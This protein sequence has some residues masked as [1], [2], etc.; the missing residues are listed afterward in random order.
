ML[1][2]AAV[3]FLL[4]VGVL[5]V[6]SQVDP[7]GRSVLFIRGADGSGGA[8]E[9]GTQQQR[10]EQ[11]SDVTN[12]NT[13]SGNHGYGT[14]RSL[15]IGDGFQVTQLIESSSAITLSALQ[16]HR[17]VVFGSNNK[18]YSAAEVQAFHDYVDRGGSA[19]F[20]SDANWGSTWEAAPASDNQFLGR[21][22]AQ[23][24]QDSGQLPLMA[25]SEQG[26]YVIADHPALSGPDGTGNK[27]DVNRYNGEGISLFRIT[28]G[29]NG[30][31]AVAMVSASG[32]QKRL[33]D[34]SGKAGALQSAG[35]GDA[36]MIF[37][38]KG[39]AR[40][41]GHFDR[42]TF[43]NLNGAGTD[44]TNL[45]N[46]QLA[47]N[48]F[49]Y[50]TSVKATAAMMGRGCGKAGALSLAA[51]LPILGRSQSY[52][53]SGASA[54]V[55]GWFVLSPGMPKTVPVGNGC[56]THVDLGTAVVGLVFVTDSAG[57][58]SF[59]PTLP[60]N[61]RLSGLRLTSQVVTFVSGGPLAGGGELSNGLDVVMGFPR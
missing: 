12:N 34:P 60:E 14:L 59:Q 55:A 32:L 29:S 5:S 38:E 9:G 25:R 8:T 41:V 56:A 26:R 7:Q 10:T 36:A 35:A 45:E 30:Y 23:V 47:L 21:Y 58:W 40:I 4:A 17:V 3:P 1:S 13:N 44:I 31:Q 24:Y 18:V 20:I 22:G 19:L 37:V 48:I 15:L 2:L 43:F 51:T 54:S 28:T 39:N 53:L 50:L 16:P 46:A 27:S 42:N 49:R 61:H 57:A 33:N 11:L 6:E 52:S